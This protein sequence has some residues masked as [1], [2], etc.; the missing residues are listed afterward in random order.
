MVGAV[1]H[2]PKHKYHGSWCCKGRDDGLDCQSCV[3]AVCVVCG[4][5]EGSLP[6][7]CPG[8]RMQ[9]VV[10]EAVYAGTVD[11]VNGQGWIETSL[12]IPTGNVTST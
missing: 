2:W 6:T 4:G 11:Y 10:E 8:E 9:G 3:L 7:A 5:A 12:R 1:L